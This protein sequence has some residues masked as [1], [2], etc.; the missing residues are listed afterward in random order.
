MLNR[1]SLAPAPAAAGPSTAQA[2]TSRRNHYIDVLKGLAALNI[3]FIH[4]VFNSGA[5][6]VPDWL[7]AVSLA[8][9]VPFFFFLSGWAVASMPAIRYQKTFASLWRIYMQWVVFVVATF[10][11]MAAVAAATTIPLGSRRD[12][13]ANFLGNL[14]L[15]NPNTPLPFHGVM[16][17]GWFLVVYFAVIPVMSFAIAFIRRYTDAM[18]PVALLLLVCLVGFVRVQAGGQFFFFGQYFLCYSAF[19]LLGFL[20]RDLFL[21]AWQA[22]AL[23]AV[24]LAGLWVALQLQG[25][26]LIHM[27][28]LKFAPSLAWVCFSLVAIVVAVFAKRWQFQITGRGPLTWVGKNAL[29]FFFTN[30]VAASL[31]MFIEPLVSLPWVA[32]LLVCYAITLS[33]TAVLVILFNQVHS[34]A[35]RGG[36]QLTAALL[37][38]L[39]ASRQSAERGAASTGSSPVP[40][41][42]SRP[43]PGSATRRPATTESAARHRVSV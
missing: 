14:V 4:T 32:K 2:G 15:E 16:G 9:D 33:I 40:V 19:F 23:I 43:A 7:R 21:R 38:S 29:Q 31:V 5:N 11:L 25:A 39:A 28:S 10:T 12:F 17:G 35:S 13:V 36:S 37:A 22:L 27:Q 24:A 26:A 1:R 3:V 41:P 30:A 20:Q 8:V 18:L 34:L 6:Y 42:R